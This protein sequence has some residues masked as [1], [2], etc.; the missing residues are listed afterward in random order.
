MFQTNARRRR[1]PSGAAPAPVEDRPC[2][3]LPD[4]VIQNIFARLPAKFVHRCRCLSR[5]WAAALASHDF[6][7]LHLSLANRHGGP[8]VLF[9]KELR[10]PGG[11]V[12]MQT[13]SPDNPIG[14]TLMEAL[15]CHS[16]QRC[17]GKLDPCFVTHQC[18]GLVILLAARMHYVLNPS[19]GRIVELPESRG[20]CGPNTAGIGLGYDTRTRTHKVVR[21]YYLPW[22][23]GCE[24]Y[25]INS[26]P[27]RW[28]PAKGCVWENLH[29]WPNNMHDMSVF[30][31]GHVYWLAKRKPISLP[32]EMYVF[33]FNLNDEMFDTL[34]LPPLNNKK[35]YQ[36]QHYLTE[37]GGRL[38]LFH[39]DTEVVN[40]ELPRRYDIWLLHG[41]DTKA[42]DLHCRIDLFEL[43]PIIPKFMRF[44][45]WV[46][47]LDVTDNGRHIII[48]PCIVPSQEPSFELCAYAPVT[49]RTESLLNGF[50]LVYSRSLTFRC[51][52]LYEESIASPGRR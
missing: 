19:T 47:L 35:Y 41:H 17:V 36:D 13:W 43:P 8:R 28:R 34:S 12:K 50:G 40:N 30:T 9:L 38:C 23:A 42:W 45:E 32:E 20:P 7:D 25:E 6:A 49:G 29:G 48:Q 46:G 2:P 14:T 22:S 18:R 31:Q 51:A 11:R 52:V 24:V 27:A 3:I 39:V 16:V 44:E 37:L 21:V 1:R 10:S 15:P 33:S 4:D 26:V 5:G